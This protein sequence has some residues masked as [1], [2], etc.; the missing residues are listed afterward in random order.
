MPRN[1]RS[2]R[3]LMKRRRAGVKLMKTGRYG[4]RRKLIARRNKRGFLSLIRKANLAVVSSNASPGSLAIADP[5]STTST[6]LV[7]IGTATLS[8]GFSSDVYD[9]P[10]SLQF[11]LGQLV[12]YSDITS[13]CDQYKLAG[14]YV[15]LFFNNNLS[16]GQYN[17]TATSMPF[18]QYI[19]DHDDAL[20][21]NVVNIRQRMGL[22]LKTFKNN[23][24]Y[25]GMMCR[26]VPSNDVYAEGAAY[27]IPGRAPWINSANAFV[28]HYAIKGV[29]NQVSLPGASDAVNAFTFDV[30]LKILGKDFQ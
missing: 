18:V 5:S 15:R 21:P 25:I 12:S 11:S 28:P 8:P 20:P 4:P 27:G 23:S 26:P 10:F 6:P 30:A 9:I 29:I 14:A 2:R 7:Q 16:I 3:R 19:T 13:L 24:S 1:Y 22:K 17:T